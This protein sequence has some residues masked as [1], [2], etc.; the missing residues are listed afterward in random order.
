MNFFRT[1]DPWSLCLR[2]PAVA[3]NGL[4]IL[5][6]LVGHTLLLFHPVG[7]T[8]VL[9]LNTITMVMLNLAAKAIRIGLRCRQYCRVTVGSPVAHRPRN[10]TTEAMPHNALLIRGLP[11]DP[12]AAGS[13]LSSEIVRSTAAGVTAL[14]LE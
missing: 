13:A 3:T 14:W 8:I 12:V 5:R 1:V 2:P 10:I 9:A 6:T 11:A 7:Y 4:R